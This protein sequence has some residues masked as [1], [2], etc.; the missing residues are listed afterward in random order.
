M[1]TTETDRLIVRRPVESDRSRLVELFT[2]EAFTVFSAG[3]HD[4][5][6]ANARF[7]QMLALYENVAPMRRNITA[8]EVGK[9]G[10]FLLSDLSSGISAEVVHVDCGFSKMGAPP[11]DFATNIQGAKD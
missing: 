7:D 5:E 8:D 11:A 10:M 4:L 6:S 1:P 2:D 3:V 9:T